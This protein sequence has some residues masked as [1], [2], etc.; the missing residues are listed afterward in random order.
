MNGLRAQINSSIH[1]VTFP[2]DDAVVLDIVDLLPD[3]RGQDRQRLQVEVN[4]E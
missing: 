1:Y 4:R 3:A 2:A